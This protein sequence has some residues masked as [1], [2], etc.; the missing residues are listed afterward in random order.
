MSLAE[1][2][3]IIRCPFFSWLSAFETIAF[4]SRYTIGS[5]VGHFYHPKPGYDYFLVLQNEVT[6]STVDDDNECRLTCVD[7]KGTWAP[8]ETPS[9]AIVPAGEPAESNITAESEERNRKWWWEER[10]KI[11]PYTDEEYGN[12]PNTFGYF[13]VRLLNSID[14]SAWET[15]PTRRQAFDAIKKWNS[16]TLFT[17]KR[18]KNY[19]REQQILDPFISAEPG[20]PETRIPVLYADGNTVNADGKAD[21]VILRIPFLPEY[22]EKDKLPPEHSEEG[23]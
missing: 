7:I 9:G 17:E 10:T 2:L 1:G 16:E 4:Q 12:K 20:D 11:I 3:R 6:F 21:I 18:L 19:N 14:K 15:L 5:L 8:H 13:I 23:K 22:S